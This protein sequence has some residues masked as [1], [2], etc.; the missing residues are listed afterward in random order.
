MANVLFIQDSWYAKLSTMQLSAV[1]KAGG[2]QT[3]LLISEKPDQRFVRS[4]KALKPDIIAISMLMTEQK[5]VRDTA[6]VIKDQGI[7]AFVIAGGPHP[8][9][10]PEFVHTRGIDAIN[11]G[12]GEASLLELAD[13]VDQKGDVSK[14]R[15][16]I[17]KNNG[18]IH[19]NP[20]RPFVDIEKLPLPDRDIYLKYD[21]FRDLEFYDFNV[22]MGCPYNCA[23]CFFHQWAGI[24]KGTK[25]YK[26]FRLKSVDRCINE[27]NDLSQKV[28]IPLIAYVDSTFNL[29]KS[30]MIEFLYRY[31]KDVNIPF[32]INLRAN[33]VDEEIVK[34]LADSGCC[35]FIRMGTEVGNERIRREVLKKNVTNQQIYDATELLRKYGIRFLTYNMFCLPGETLEQA[36]ET[37]ELNQKIRPFA[38][39]SL[40]FHPYPGLEVTK[41]ALE[42]GYLKEEDIQK[43]EKKRYNRMQSVLTQKDLREIENLSKLSLLAVMYPSTFPVVKRLVKLPPNIV[44]D[45]IGIVSRINSGVKAMEKN[46]FQLVM[47]L[48][49]EGKT[50]LV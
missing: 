37:I 17:V 20:V 50:R 47:K 11:V 31:K 4:V 2:H 36:F 19:E 14:I 34:A 32:T 46:F 27:I 5:W 1:L 45:A 7:D 6:G 15:N 13:T 40:I 43:L 3:D 41:Y 30:W 10:F 42:K 8:T 21:Y 26:P 49:I 23:Y 22:S 28:K 38:M 12:E 44:F 48:I 18:E 16:L 39:N 33:L 9:F 35:R 25:G 29:K 24:Y